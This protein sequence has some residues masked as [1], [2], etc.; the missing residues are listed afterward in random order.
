[1]TASDT[2]H[3]GLIVGNDTALGAWNPPNK[4]V[5]APQSAIGGI[6]HLTKPG[7]PRVVLDECRD[8]SLL[9]LGAVGLGSFKTLL[10]GSTAEWF[11]R[12][13]SMPVALVR[14]ATITHD[15]LFCV[16]GSTHA[17]R[18]VAAVAA[19]PWIGTVRAQLLTVDDGRADNDAAL[20]AA[21]DILDSAGVETTSTRKRGRATYVIWDALARRG[22]SPPLVVMGTR[23]L[24]NLRRLWT[25]S[26][27]AAV[28]RHYVGNVIVASEGP[29]HL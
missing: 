12:Q 27:A 19:L 3:A 7:D 13:P 23:G 2:L 21:A 9:V 8:A 26:T 1:V 11:L 4:R 28:A 5:L 24:T 14:S 29:G 20:K 16:D 6:R 15:V 25:G 17:Q 18:A 10:V 22:E